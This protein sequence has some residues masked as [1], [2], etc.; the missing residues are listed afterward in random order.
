[1]SLPDIY[2]LSRE[3]KFSICK[4]KIF[5][6]TLGEKTIA[7]NICEYSFCH[8]ILNDRVKVYAIMRFPTKMIKYELICLKL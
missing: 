2:S 3:E 7:K 6:Q 4:S 8:F 1:M 5:E